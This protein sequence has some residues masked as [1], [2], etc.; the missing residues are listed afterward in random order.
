MGFGGR[1]R[2]V[3]DKRENPINYKGFE[4]EDSHLSESRQVKTMTYVVRGKGAV[5]D[6]LVGLL[7]ILLFFFFSKLM[8][9]IKTQIQNF[10]F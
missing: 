5:E 8:N 4:L 6:I 7:E 10:F 1:F 9:S 2:K 3:I